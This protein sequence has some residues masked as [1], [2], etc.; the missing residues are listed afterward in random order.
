MN[1]D[2]HTEKQL[3]RDLDEVSQ[4]W[5]AREKT[6]PPALVDQAVMNRA[7]RA[8]EGNGKPAR[9]RF[10]LR[11][12]GALATASVVV[13]A[14]TLVVEQVDKAPLPVSAEQ[15]GLRLDRD[16]NGAERQMKRMEAAAPAAAREAPVNQ[17][18][19][20]ESMR[21]ETEQEFRDSA[22]SD[23]TAA[24]LAPEPEAWIQRLLEM[25][26]LNDE[27][28]AAELA[29]FRAAYPDYPLPPGLEK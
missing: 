24:G 14:L 1:I 4:A 29:A 17:N 19:Q 25:K 20:A 8:L 3:E 27:N 22:E 2:T 6:E 23:E 15:D 18:L 13:L 21:T 7:R 5:T 11:W 9:K 12:L 26:R 16:T 10:R 28:L